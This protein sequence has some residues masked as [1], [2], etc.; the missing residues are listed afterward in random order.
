MTTV[1]FKNALQIYY[2]LKSTYE[3]SK[4]KKS[5]STNKIHINIII[6]KCVHCHRPVGTFFSSIY[7]EEIQSRILIARCGDKIIPCNLNI[8]I[9]TGI[10]ASLPVCI[11]Q[12]EDEMNKL[13]NEIINLKNQVL[14]GYINADVLLKSFEDL[15]EIL[16][17]ATTLL[18]DYYVILI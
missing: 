5:T 8:R 9:Q 4:P 11:T 18:T 7:D 10:S 13:R 17:E 12:L 6:P 14:F 15:K 3:I 1:S 2:K 16:A